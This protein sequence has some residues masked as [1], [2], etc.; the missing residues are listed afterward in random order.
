M[1]VIKAGVLPPDKEYK[2]ICYYCGCEFECVSSDLSRSTK[3][4][5]YYPVANCPTCSAEVWVKPKESK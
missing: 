5:Y 4:Y 1:K 2:G 3:Y